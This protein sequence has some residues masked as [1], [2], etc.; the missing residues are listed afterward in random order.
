MQDD[1]THAEA[2]TVKSLPEPLLTAIKQRPRT[3]QVST[4]HAWLVPDEETG[5]QENKLLIP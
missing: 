5:Q 2:E 3:K 1:P 4:N